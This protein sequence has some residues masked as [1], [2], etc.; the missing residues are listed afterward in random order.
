MARIKINDL[1]G[2][3][4]PS[5][6][7]A[8]VDRKGTYKY[9][10]EYEEE[11]FDYIIKRT[12]TPDFILTFKDGRKIYIEAKGYFRDADQKKMRAIKEQHP[13]LDI[14]LLFQNDGKITNTKMRYSDWCNKYKFPFAIWPNIPEDWFE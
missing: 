6:L 9:K 14:R 11:V 8:L 3:F 2:G 10:L 13:E 5:V 12:Y 1:K 7:K 4:E